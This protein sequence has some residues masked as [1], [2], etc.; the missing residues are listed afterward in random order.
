MAD[1]ACEF[2]KQ[3]SGRQRRFW[4]AVLVWWLCVVIFVATVSAFSK[5]SPGGVV[6]ALVYGSALLLFIPARH[7]S[8]L[9][10]PYCHK[11]AGAVPFFRYRFVICKACG[12]R[13][14]CDEKK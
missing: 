1:R 2:L 5:N 12:E 11:S 7:M 10:C 4:L 6:T 13:I 8:R 3:V 14:E 9:K